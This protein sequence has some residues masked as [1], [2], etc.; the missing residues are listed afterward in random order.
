M[1]DPSKPPRSS[2]IDQVIVFGI[3]ARFYEKPGTNICAAFLANNDTK[4]AQTINFR[5]REFL[6][7]PRSISILPD[8]KTVVFNTETVKLLSLENLRTVKS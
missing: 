8:C 1:V 7:P 2:S 6:L 3:Q 5:G 4:S